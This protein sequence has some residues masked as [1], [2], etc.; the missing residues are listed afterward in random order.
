MM[1]ITLIDLKTDLESTYIFNPED[2]IGT[3]KKIVAR[4]EGYNKE[5]DDKLVQ[6]YWTFVKLDD[7]VLVKDYA[8]KEGIFVNI[9]GYGS[10][11]T[12]TG[13]DVH[14]WFGKRNHYKLTENTSETINPRFNGHFAVIS[15]NRYVK[16]HQIPNMFNLK[17]FF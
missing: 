8:D 5:G 9:E 17:L 10:Q 16:S 12:V 11:F 13:G 4:K 1:E 6:I 3:L 14:V 15:S 7:S 2:T